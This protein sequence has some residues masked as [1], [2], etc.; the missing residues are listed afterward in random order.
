MRTPLAHRW[1]TGLER[2]CRGVLFASVAIAGGVSSA[3]AEDEVSTLLADNM[4]KAEDAKFGFGSGSIIVAPIPLKSPALGNGLILTGGYL[5]KLDEGS[6]TSFI[7][8]ARMKTSNGSIGTGAAANL[9]FDDA[10]WSIQALLGKAKVNYSIYGIGSVR[11]DPVPLS[12]EGDFARLGFGYGLTDSL[13]LG[14]DA[15]YLDTTIRSAEAGGVQFP[16]LPGLDVGVRQVVLGP[17]ITFDTRD[18]TIYPTGGFYGSFLV[19]RGIGI[20]DFDNAFTK[21]TAFARTYMPVAENGVLALGA[22]ACRASREAPFFNMCSVGLTDGLRGFAAGQYIDNALL[23][24][25]AEF[26]YRLGS[27]WG[28]T[29]FAGASMVGANFSDMGAPL[30]AGGLGFRFRLS[31]D[32]P[33][34]FS[35]DQTLNSEGDS[36]T[37]VYIGQ[38]F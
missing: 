5:F 34:D 4:T 36:F 17:E 14:I 3:A 18:D 27:R 1:R 35:V 30:Y 26:R 23:S 33:L 11:F 29:V 37:Y 31:K 12:Q 16:N 19:Q 21:G 22:T 9:S 15:Q 20:G 32:F 25:Q 2:V 28:A 13:S 38:S 8:A 6:D 7:G 10:R 24:A